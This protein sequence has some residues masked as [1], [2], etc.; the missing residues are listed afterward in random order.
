[1]K[2]VIKNPAPLDS[3]LHKWGDYH[4]GRLL[5]KHLSRHGET[6][7]THYYGS[8]DQDTDCD[9][10]LLLRGKH[11]FAGQPG[12]HPEA[13]WVLWNISHPGDVSD[14][15]CASYDLVAIASTPQ[16]LALDARIAPPVAAL[17]QCTDP[18]EFRVGEQ[19]AGDLRRGF[20]FVGNTRATLRP[21]VL[22]AIEYGLPLQIWGRGWDRWRKTR[23]CVVADYYPNERLGHLYSRSKATINDHWDDMKRYGFINNRVFDALACGLPVVSDWHEQLAQHFPDEVMYYR[24][25][26]E[27]EGCMEWLL[28]G[29]PDVQAR[30]VSAIA[31][32]RRQFSFEKRAAELIDLA[33]TNKSS[34]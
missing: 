9:V 18:E 11:P 19:A 1:M 29:Y 2:W 25:E 30:A 17:L 20:V 4:F 3:R 13:L 15:E 14:E 8:W 23:Q 10:V 21:G 6:V 16:A 31:T 5:A 28:L 22:W 26:Q 32:I 33:E 24:D 27:F 12:Q 7:E 34:R